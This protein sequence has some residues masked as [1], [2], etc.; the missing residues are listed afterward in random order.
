[1]ITFG[2]ITCSDTRDES[3]DTAG[4]FLKSAIEERSWKVASYIVVK[5]ERDAIGDAIVRACD[6]ACVDVVITCGGTGLSRRD[7]T[8]EATQD[9]CD[10]NVPGIAEGIRAYG[11]SHTPRAMLSRALC[12]QRG[13]SLVINFP[14]SRKAA[15]ECWEGVVEVLDHAVSM[16]AGGGH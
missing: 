7:V 16:M 13:S 1:M 4:A 9:V 10:R 15:Q 12:M 5:D 14:G 11:L 8:P 6:E 3:Q 2:L